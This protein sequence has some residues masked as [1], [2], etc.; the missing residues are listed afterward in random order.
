MF[1]TS[2]AFRQLEEQRL[3]AWDWSNTS[4]LYVSHGWDPARGGA[5]AI[6]GRRLVRALLT[7]GAR[8]HVLAA[9]RAD[10]ELT[11]PR[12]GITAVEGPPMAEGRIASAFQM[13]CSGVPES[14]GRWVRNAVAAGL[15]LAPSLPRNTIIYGRSSP[16]SSNIAAWHLARATGLPWVA[17]FSDEWPPRSVLSNGRRWLVPYKAP[18]FTLWRHRI[19]RDAGALTFSNPRQAKEVLG[20]HARR[21][22][23]KAFVVA[24]LPSCLVP[25]PQPPQFETFHIVH[26]GNFYHGQSPA[27]LLQGLGLFLERNPAAR[28]RVRFSQAGWCEG[29]VTALTR[30]YGLDDVVRSTGRLAE[31]DLLALMNQAT[32]LVVV[33]YHRADSTTVH[34]K[35]PDYVNARRPIL[36]ITAPGTSLSRLFDGDG[37]GLTA[38][39]DSAE[40]V[41]E[42]LALVFDAW[43]QQQLGSLLPGPHAIASYDWKRV[44]RELSGAFLIAR[45]RV[46]PSEY[47]HASH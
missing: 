26:A 18:L 24:H 19:I 22:E 11:S 12:Y 29:D 30:R 47:R 46:R 45:D 23:H 34:S 27:P 44:L 10:E 32:L 8:V 3:R 7:A 43:Q 38:H 6:T 40:E 4:I 37:A 14:A 16:G 41:A 21:F 9:G 17:H 39:Y 35:I 13:V 31:H 2:S 1:L 36:A 20:A 28:H 25:Q 33:D 5:Q 15:R 42:R